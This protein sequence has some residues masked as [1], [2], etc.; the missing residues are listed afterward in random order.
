MNKTA[1][2]R[3]LLKIGAVLML[4]FAWAIIPFVMNDSIVK[5]DTA[6][7]IRI[8]ASLTGAAI[9]GVTPS[10]FSEH[11]YEPGDSS[12]ERRRLEVQV[13]SV[14]L[15]NG[16]ALDVYVGST[17][18]GQIFINNGFGFVEFD[19]NDGQNVPNAANGTPV[20]VRQGTTDIVTGVFGIY[21]PSPSPSVSPSGSPNP[22][23][24]VSPS[25]SPS[26]SPSGSPSPSPSVSPSAS[27]SPTVS[28]SPTGSPSPS[29]TGSPS[30]SPSPN[31]GDLFAVLSG[32]TINGVLP[33]GLAQYELHSS[34][35]ELEI[36]V[37]QVNLSA[38]T[39]LAVTVD[40]QSVGQLFIESDGRGKLRL[41]TDNGQFVPNVVNG[42]IINLTN[43]SAA[44]LAGVFVGASPSPSPSPSASPSPSPS[45]SPSPSPSAS[46]SPSPSGSPSPSPSASPSPSPSP[47]A[48]PTPALGRYFEAQTTGSQ[49]IPPVTTG[50]TGKISVLLNQAETEATIT[51]LFNNLSSAQTTA[52]IF[53]TAG[54]TN[55]VHE[56]AAIGGTNGTLVTAT[57]PVN[58]LQIAQLRTGLWFGVIGSANNPGGEVGGRLRTQSGSSDFDGDGRQDFSVYRPTAGTWYAQNTNGFSAQVFGG[59]NDKLVSGDYDGDGRTDAAV[60]RNENGIGVWEVKRSSDG[61][62]TT[63]A[64]G[65]ATDTTQRGDFD[66]DGRQD[67]AVFRPSTGAWYIQKSSNGAVVGVNFGAAEDKATA[68]DFDGD[69]KTD[70]AV[71]R[72]STGT[73]YW[74]RSSDGG[75]RAAA[76]GQAGDVPVAGD[77]DGDGKSDLSVFRPANG[78]WYIQRS[79]NGSFDFRQ[80]GLSDDIPVAGNYDGDNKTDI[81][82]F[83]P[84]TGIWYI[85]RSL[86]GTFDYR[87]FGQNGDVP[88]PSR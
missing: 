14:N 45:G 69:G 1:K 51:G 60:V 30:P 77:F 13:F 3:N 66:G 26:P 38:G 73:W 61:G 11:R 76:F 36:E 34:R 54:D 12:D 49:M 10:G 9:N 24:S 19:T 28:P 87:H 72:P 85:W 57:I 62:V 25:G 15:P 79:S 55:L 84:S 46:P 43:G 29:P 5:A 71:F 64:F 31:G 50:A 6:S 40:G 42:S 47:S 8:R 48:S 65:F 80:F 37:N 52:K 63:R 32:A 39:L 59:A 16:T 33:N 68:T 81:A 2:N 58:A 88:T 70:I 23:P 82:V 27:P 4:A 56:F 41:R 78:V 75:F 21:T 7:D 35:R 20:A 74:L 83:R 53:S 44:I 67:L 18:V 86:D 22:S 17:F